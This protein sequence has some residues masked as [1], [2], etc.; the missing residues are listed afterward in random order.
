MPDAIHFKVATRKVSWLEC[1]IGAAQ[2]L[3]A[4]VIQAVLV[5]RNSVV[6]G[7]IRELFV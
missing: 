4:E 1:E 5:V 2:R 3:L 7:A 6:V